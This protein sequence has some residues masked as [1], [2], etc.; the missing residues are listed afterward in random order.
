MST[1]WKLKLFAVVLLT[2]GMYFNDAFAHEVEGWQGVDP[3]SIGCGKQEG[4]ER[5]NGNANGRGRDGVSNSGGPSVTGNAGG[6]YLIP[7]KSVKPDC[8]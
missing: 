8:K 6:G 3:H 1:A 2:T 7:P 4:C 5:H